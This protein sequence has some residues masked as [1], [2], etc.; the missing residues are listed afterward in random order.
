MPSGMTPTISERLTV[1]GARAV[2]D[3][4]VAEDLLPGAVEQDHMAPVAVS[5]LGCRGATE[6]WL[7]AQDLPD[8]QAG[9]LRVVSQARCR[10]LL[11]ARPG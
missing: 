2:D 3:T 5:F 7:D 11:S 1:E 6:K 8:R 4:W 9:G 10:P